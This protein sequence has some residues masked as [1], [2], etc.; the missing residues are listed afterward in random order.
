MFYKKEGFGSSFL[1]KYCE[2]GFENIE[3]RRENY[4]A[5][6]ERLYSKIHFKEC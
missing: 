4:I 3:D 2:N 1:F 5:L 6:Y